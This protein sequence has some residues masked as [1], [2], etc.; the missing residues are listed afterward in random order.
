MIELFSHILLIRAINHIGTKLS[1][2]LA[3]GDKGINGLDELCK[4]HDIAYG[5]H[6]DSSERAKADEKLKSGAI[7]RIFARDASLGERAASVLV[8]T[9]MKV[10]TGLSK[11]GMGLPKRKHKRKPKKK[12]KG[13]TTKN[14]KKS[15]QQIAF[16]AL[17]KDAKHGI[18]KSGA[19]TIR[20][21]I[22][23]ALRSAK[24][25]GKGKRIKVPRIIK[26]PSITGGV[27]PLLPILAGLGAIGSVIGSATGIVKTIK[28]MNNAKAQ[29]QENKRHNLAME[30][31]IGSGLYLGMQKKGNGLYLRPHK[32]GC[33]L[34]LN[35]RQNSKNFH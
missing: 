6:K 17:V 12:A 22:K 30:Q 20:T 28:D 5:A 27:L 29:L 10:K 2:R 8:S 4:E 32:Q 26:V 11:I 19:K 9:A 35:P 24:K 16:S 25:R 34:Y 14:Q 33:G 23:A 31:K 21:A 13:K 15:P 1:E 18:K 7:K 3:R